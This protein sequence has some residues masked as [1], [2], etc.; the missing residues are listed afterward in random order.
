[1]LSQ[2]VIDFGMISFHYPTYEISLL[3]Q[4]RKLKRVSRSIAKM[5]SSMQQTLL[6]FQISP[7]AI[8]VTL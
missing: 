4:N 6:S 5:Y 1:M 3:Y 2:G 8:I 7:L